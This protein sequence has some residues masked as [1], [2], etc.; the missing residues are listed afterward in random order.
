M[1]F[2]GF[3]LSTEQLG[4]TEFAYTGFS[5]RLATFSFA[6]LSI[7]NQA[8]EINFKHFDFLLFA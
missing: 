5:C 3:H 8:M 7:I 4:K 2:D 6:G 1:V